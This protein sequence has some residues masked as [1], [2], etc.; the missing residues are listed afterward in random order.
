MSRRG[1]P[2]SSRPASC[3]ASRSRTSRGWATMSLL[4]VEHVVVQF[5][6]VTAV[7]DAS[8]QVEGGTITGLIGPN[9]AGKTT[10][11]NVI[12]GM[13]PPTAGRV[14]LEGQDITGLGTHARA[15]RGIARTFQRLEAFGSLSVRENV[16]VAAEIH[17]R[18]ARN[19]PDP[20]KTA[21]ELVRRV[22]IEK[23]ASAQA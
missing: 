13:Q 22:G 3:A 21:E 14:R 11:F 19:S 23:W 2:R 18:W 17:G 15:R 8:F 12:T 10:L 16:L 1:C 20:R 4:Q 7:N 5:G 6:G 9:G